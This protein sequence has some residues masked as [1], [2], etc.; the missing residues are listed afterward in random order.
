MLSVPIVSPLTISGTT[1]I[2]SGSN[3]VPGTW[4]ERGSRCA[5]LA[6]TASPWSMTQPVMPGPERALVGEDQVGEP[7]AGDDRAADAGLRSTR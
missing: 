6:R 3:G 5:S 7:V 4:T 2:D 1:I